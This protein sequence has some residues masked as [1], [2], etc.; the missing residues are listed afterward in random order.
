M[1]L[2]DRFVV[3]TM[4]LVP[5]S[6][7]GKVASRYI[8]GETLDDAVRTVRGLNQH[9]MLATVDVLGEF[10][11]RRKEA[12]L[13]VE[14]YLDLLRAIKQENLDTGI[15][16]K[17]TAIG[18]SID[19]NFTRDNLLRIADAALSQGTFIRIDMEDSPYTDETLK[20][21][22][23]SRKKLDRGVGVA[24]QAYLRRAVDDVARLMDGGY[25]DFRLCKGIYIE[26]ESIAYKG[27]EEVQ[28]N[29]LRLLEQMFDAGARVGIATHD[30]YLV[31]Q[32]EAMIERRKI[33]RDLYEFQMLLG[34][35]PD[36]RDRILAHGHQ[37]RIYVPFGEEWYGYST[38]R[39]KE[40]PK[41]AGYVFRNM[42]RRD[43]KPVLSG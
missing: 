23:E 4:P 41:V 28:A 3:A 15:S 39:L 40:N 13:S 5:R 29:F 8:A 35:R 16:V 32:S 11:N 36:I 43:S 30:P 26:P 31:E 17:L 7:V 20:I 2:L 42:F 1:S 34:V 38:R 33:S 12:E 14:C 24:I 18:L 37:L 6:L 19:P 10:V 22:D 25:A 27:F 9:G 21:Y